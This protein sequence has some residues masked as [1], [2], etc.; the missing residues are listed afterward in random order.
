MG[1]E[2]SAYLNLDECPNCPSVSTLSPTLWRRRDWS[3]DALPQS[4]GSLS[5]APPSVSET[6]E[7]LMGA[8]GERGVWGD[9]ERGEAAA[10]GSY[11]SGL[12]RSRT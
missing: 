6:T 3:Q 10:V 2:L 1:H 12:L 5:T 8:G 11:D 9:L 7:V 4:Q